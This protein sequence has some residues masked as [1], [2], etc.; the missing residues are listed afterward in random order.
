MKVRDL[1]PDTDLRTV[2]VR[3]PEEYREEAESTGLETMEV[4]VHSGWFAGTWVKAD[5]F[6]DRIYPLQIQSELVLDW[7]VVE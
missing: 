6:K 5:R 3:I 1:P 2:R 7:E 4:Y